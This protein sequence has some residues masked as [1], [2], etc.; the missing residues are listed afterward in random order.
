[1]HWS[2]FWCF[3]ILEGRGSVGF[4]L[5]IESA[6]WCLHIHW[7]NHN[8]YKT[9]WS[10]DCTSSLLVPPG[11]NFT[12]W[13]FDLDIQNDV[14]GLDSN[15]FVSNKPD[16]PVLCVHSQCKL[17][18]VSEEASVFERLKSLLGLRELG[19][20]SFP[21][22]RCQVMSYWMFG[23]PSSSLQSFDKEKDIEGLNIRP[24]EKVFLL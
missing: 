4:G 16:C 6:Q 17:Q 21:L 13:R 12:S 24:P 11:K 3:G 23:S 22:Q 7:C 5:K 8:S 19:S 15:N 9:E 20:Y 14:S 1:M 2:V 10:L 18:M